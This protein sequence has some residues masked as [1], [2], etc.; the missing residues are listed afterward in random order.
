[1]TVKQWTRSLMNPDEFDAFVMCSPY[2]PVGLG[3]S[4]LG[5]TTLSAQRVRSTD[6][7]NYLNDQN[8]PS[9]HFFSSFRTQADSKMTML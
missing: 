1:M 9:M 8:I 3:W 6:Y 7:L 2:K 5:S 4:G